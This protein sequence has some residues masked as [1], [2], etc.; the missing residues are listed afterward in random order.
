MTRRTL[1]WIAVA[2]VTLLIELGATI[3]T[4]GGTP[5]S[6]VE[7]W[8]PTRPTDALAFALVTT[9]SLS[10]G[11]FDRLPV[12]AALGC[13]VSYLVFALRD[14]ELGLFL[15]PMIVIFALT[16]KSGRL[17]MAIICAIANLGAAL[18]WVGQRTLTIHDPG[19]AL[20]TWVAFG[21]VLGV[22]FVAP[23][24]VG[25]IVRLRSGQRRA[26]APERR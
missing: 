5:F 24:L 21:T 18:V 16:A 4:V 22:F 17:S 11:L 14:Y 13:T 19:A 12:A 2:V 1:I 20:L 6:S 26:P 10:L 23:I 8:G 15:P 25:E 7:G 3:G 9:G